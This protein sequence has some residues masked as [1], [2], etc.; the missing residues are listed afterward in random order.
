VICL[1]NG[2]RFKRGRVDQLRI[3]PTMSWQLL[4][5]RHDR[6]K[7]GQ[8]PWMPQKI[9]GPEPI[10][11]DAATH[12]QVAPWSVLFSAFTSSESSSA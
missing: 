4:I 11:R 2:P 1:R 8:P 3:S 10:G 7:I 6:V 12:E 5:T 9:M